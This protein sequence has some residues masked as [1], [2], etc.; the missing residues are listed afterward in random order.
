M[1]HILAYSAYFL[2]KGLFTSIVAS[3]EKIFWTCKIN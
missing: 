2:T 1:V 3:F